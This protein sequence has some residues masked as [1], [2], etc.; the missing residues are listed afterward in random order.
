MDDDT[1]EN[2]L[3]HLTLEQLRE[4]AGKASIGDPDAEEPP[5]R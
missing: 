2:R 1:I 4:W 5:Q 3:D